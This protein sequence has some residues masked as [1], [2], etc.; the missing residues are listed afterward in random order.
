MVLY[1]VGGRVLMDNRTGFGT[2]HQAISTLLAVENER[3]H[4]WYGQRQR[5]VQDAALLKR[6]K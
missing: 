3:V 5:E 4:T 2:F 6:L 1:E